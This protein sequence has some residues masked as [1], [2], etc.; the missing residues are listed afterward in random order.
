MAVS[1]IASFIV[2][3]IVVGV[4]SDIAANRH[5]DLRSEQR[6]ETRQLMRETCLLVEATSQNSDLAG[7]WQ[8]PAGVEF[9]TIDV[10]GSR[11]VCHF[12]G[13]DWSPYV[14]C[15]DILDRDASYETAWSAVCPEEAD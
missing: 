10:W 14:L 1:F 4:L 6:D 9:Q 11:A 5:Y 15:F 7:K 8:V 13:P 3:L 2:G 12:A